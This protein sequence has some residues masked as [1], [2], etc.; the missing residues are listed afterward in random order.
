MLGKKSPLFGRRT[1]QMQLKPFGYA[2]AARFHPGWS[3]IEQARA[4]FVCGGLPFYLRCF[5]PERSVEQNLAAAMFDELGPLF[6]EPEFLLREELRETANYHAILMSLAA[7]HATNSALA[8]ATGIGERKLHFYLA[9]LMDLGY[10][11]RRYPLTGAPP[12]PRQVRYA[13][14]DPLLRFWFR[15]IFPNL[16]QIARIS[17][18]QAVQQLVRPALDA[19]FGYAF[20]RLCREA[21]PA[22]YARE[23]VSA[24]YEIGEYWD[25]ETQIDVVGLRQDG[26]TDLGEC[27]WAAV[28][29]AGALRTE[30]DAR[31]GRFPNRR[32]ATIG[33]RFFTRAPGPAATA[34]KANERWHSLD[35]L[36]EAG[37]AAK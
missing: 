33:R 19:F 24:P 12:T 16:S 23:G 17:P 31:V 13:L 22:L 18:A 32:G 34:Q 6:R 1:G 7:G 9:T 26:W 8:L 14:E 4:Y 2:E 5:A 11:Q 37:D 10:V 27:K 28:R 20:E 25:K 3:R 29:S 35:D 21:L 30:M 36:Y 15:F